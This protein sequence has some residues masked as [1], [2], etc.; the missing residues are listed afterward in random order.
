MTAFDCEWAD[1]LN[2]VIKAKSERAFKFTVINTRST[3]K[4]NGKRS[5]STM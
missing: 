5:G 2:S 4:G 3:R 1:F